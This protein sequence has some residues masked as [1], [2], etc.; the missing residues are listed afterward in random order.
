MNHGRA[1][2]EEELAYIPCWLPVTFR[3]EENRDVIA[4]H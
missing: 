4:P 2:V 1:D 3:T